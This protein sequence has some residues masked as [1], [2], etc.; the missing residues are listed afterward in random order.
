MNLFPLEWFGLVV[1]QY[2]LEGGFVDCTSEACQRDSG[3]FRSIVRDDDDPNFWHFII[4]DLAFVKIFS[5]EGG[6][7]AHSAAQTVARDP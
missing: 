6:S 1:N 5:N 3:C 4:H 7:L 2:Q